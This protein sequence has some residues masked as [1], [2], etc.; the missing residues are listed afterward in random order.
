MGG[1]ALFG[2]VL[3]AGSKVVLALALFSVLSHW[4]FL[5][6]VEK[7]TDSSPVDF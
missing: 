7:C 3:I 6:F 5:S 1:A 2:L 4:W